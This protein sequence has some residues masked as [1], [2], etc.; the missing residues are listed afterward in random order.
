MG[1]FGRWGFGYRR[2][3]S[4]I[5]STGYLRTCFFDPSQPTCLNS[6]VDGGWAV[7]RGYNYGGYS[8]YTSPSLVGRIY[9][10]SSCTYGPNRGF[11]AYC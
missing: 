11:R 6:L 1:L 2:N 10:Y 3:L 9:T 5:P 7:N 4:A 8:H